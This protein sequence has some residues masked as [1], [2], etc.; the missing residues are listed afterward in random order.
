M[1]RLA[2]AATCALYSSFRIIVLRAS[3]SRNNNQF[4][5]ADKQLVLVLK[6]SL[7]FTSEEL[8]KLDCWTTDVDDEDD[9]D[10]EDMDVDDMDEDDVI[11]AIWDRAEEAADDISSAGIKSLTSRLKDDG[12]DSEMAPLLLSIRIDEKL[13]LL[14]ISLLICN[15][16]TISS[17]GA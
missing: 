1:R 6:R 3:F 2:V 8:T 12:T 11:E 5:S 17:L 15:T 7:E 4:N 9:S 13:L 14:L 16:P 10:V